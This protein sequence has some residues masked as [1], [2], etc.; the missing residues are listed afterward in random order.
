MDS[1]TITVSGLL[2]EGAA[3]TATPVEVENDELNIVLAFDISIYN[4]DGT[5]FEPEDDTISVTIQSDEISAGNGVYYISDDGD[6]EKMESEA[7]E[8][9]VA[10]DAEHFSTYAVTDSDTVVASGTIDNA[11]GTD[12]ITWTVYDDDA[13][14]RYLVITGTGAIPDYSSAAEQPWRSYY[15]STDCIVIG[16]GITKIGNYAFTSFKATEIQFSNT[17]SEIGK[18]A[19]SGMS[20]LTEVTIPG[21]VKTIGSD[22][23]SAC[24]IT[25]ITLGEGVQTIADR[26]FAESG[27]SVGTVAIPASVTSIDVNAFNSIE[28]FDVAEKNE[29]YS[30][31]E[32]ILFSKDGTKLIKYPNNKEAYSYTVEGG[33]T[34]GTKAFSQVYKTSVLYIESDV[35]FESGGSYFSESNFI[36][37]YFADDVVISDTSGYWFYQNDNLETVKLP[38]NTSLTL[39][40][41][42]FYGDY[43][44][45]ELTIPKGTQTIGRVALNGLNA[46]QTLTYDAANVTSI[47]STVVSSSMSYDLIVGKDVDTLP[48]DFNY[49]ASQALSLTF[50]GPNVINVAEGALANALAPFTGI[51]GWIYVDESGAVYQLD[52]NSNTATL[53]YVPDDV[54]KYTV[55][56][57]FTVSG[58]SGSVNGT[59]KVTTVASNALKYADSLTSITFA[60]ASQ[61][62]LEAYA[63][64][65]CETLTSVINGAA[66]E[67]GTAATV[68]GAEALGFARVGKNA[69]YNTGLT[70][71]N[72]TVLSEMTLNGSQSV[73]ANETNTSDEVI[74]SITAR[75]SDGGAW[76][77]S[78]GTTGGYVA[79][80][81]QDM[82]VNI[83]ASNS[84]GSPQT[85]R[86]YFTS[87]DDDFYM[88]YEVG[89]TYSIEGV[90]VAWYQDPDDPYTV[91]CEFTVGAH[92]TLNFDVP[93][94]YP[95]GSSDGGGLTVSTAIVEKTTDEGGTTTTTETATSSATLQLWWKTEPDEYTLTKTSNKTSVSIAANAEGAYL[96]D[97]L[98]Y[99]IKLARA[100]D[101]HSSLG[102]DYVTS[103][104]YTDILTLPDGVTWDDAV[105]ESIKNGTYTRSIGNSGNTVTFSANGTTI[106]TLAMTSTTGLALQ[107]VKLGVDKNGQVVLSWTVKNTG[108]ENLSKNEFKLTIDSAALDVTL[109]SFDTS[110]N[111]VTNT[112]TSEVNYTYSQSKTKTANATTALTVSNGT[113][114]VSKSA[115][116][117]VTYFGEDK[118]YTVTVANSGATT[119]TYTA[120][121]MGAYTLTDKLPDMV[122]IKAENME[123]MF[124]AAEEA[125]T[126]LTITITGAVLGTGGTVSD[127]DSNGTAYINSGNS[128]LTDETSGNTIVIT[129]SNGT[130]TISVTDA[131]GNVTTSSGDDLE[132]L[133]Q[134]IGYGVTQSAVYTCTWTMASETATYTL[135]P[136]E[137]LTYS[138]LSTVKTTFQYLGTDAQQKYQAEGAVPFT[139]TR[140]ELLDPSSKSVATSSSVSDSAKRE[141]VIDKSVYASDSEE[142]LGSNFTAED[143]QVLT[144]ELT[145]THYGSGTYDDLPMV[146]DL[147][148][149]QYL[150]VPYTESGLSCSEGSNYEAYDA[151]GD[152]TYDYY[153]LKSGTFYNVEVGTY[154]MSDGTSGTLTAAKI[155]VSSDSSEEVLTDGTTFTYSGVHT[156]IYWYFD[157][158]PSGNYTL[159]VDY[160]ALVDY[161]GSPSY[162]LGNVVW[163][164]DRTNARIYDTLLG[165]G[166]VLDWDK[167]IVTSGADDSDTDDDVID[168]D[169]LSE[170]GEGE[171][172]T[173]RLTLSSGGDADTRVILTGD[174]IADALPSTFGTFTWTANNVAITN[175]IVETSGGGQVDGY[176]ALKDSTKWSIESSWNGTTSEGQYYILWDN[177]VSITFT[178]KATVYVY[179]TLTFPDDTD[180][181]NDGTSDWTEYVEAVS[182][183]TLSNTFYVYN[184]P[185]TVNHVLKEEGSAKLTKGVYALARGTLNNNSI[186]EVYPTGSTKE[187]YNNEDSSNRYI[188]YYV[189]LYNGANSRLYLNDLYDV[190]PDGFTFVTLISGSSNYTNGKLETKSTGI[191]SI[192]TLDSSNSSS[193]WLIEKDS[194]V[195]YRSATITASVESGQVKFSVGSGS[196]TY[197]IKYDDEMGQYYL[198]TNE[199]IVFGFICQIGEYAD[200]ESNATNT[201]AMSYTDYTNAGDVNVAEHTV[202][203]RDFSVDGGATK[204]YGGASND[205]DCKVHTTEEVEEIGISD[206]TGN[207][208]WL[209]SDVTVSRGGIVPGVS[210][211]VVS[212]T[213]NNGDSTPYTT[214]VNTNMTVN[215]EATLY[216]RGT[217]T[218]YNYTVTDAMPS[219]F[220]F[221]RDVTYSIFDSTDT[222]LDTGTLFSFPDTGSLTSWID[223]T[224]V[225][226]S[227]LGANGSEAT[228]DVTVGGDAVTITTSKG[229]FT[230][231]LY[232]SGS[233][234][235]M[236]IGFTDTYWAIPEGGHV[237]L[238]YS[239]H[240]PTNEYVNATYINTVT[241][242]PNSQQ[243]TE[244]DTGRKTTD[245]TGVYATAP[246]TVATGYSTSAYKSVTEKTDTTNTARSDDSDNSIVLPSTDSTFTYTLTV[247]NSTSA[248]MS[249][250]VLIDN[251]PYVGDTY[252]FNSDVARGS[253]FAV[254]LANT[255]FTVTITTSEGTTT[256]G[257]SYYTVEG[258]TKKNNFTAA[259]KAGTNSTDW[260][261]I[262]ADTDLPTVKSIRVIIN[263]NIPAG[264]TV[265]VSFDGKVSGTANAGAVAWNNFGYTY[266][267]T[268]GGSSI[269]LEAMPLEVG[270]QVPS[271]PKL[272]KKLVDLEGND[273]KVD[274]NTTFTFVVYKGSE[275]KD[276][277]GNSYTSKEALITALGQTQ[278]KEVTITVDAEASNSGYVSL[279]WSDWTWTPNT[280]YTIT[281][282]LEGETY[283]LNK[284]SASGETTTGSQNGN[285]YTF[286]YDPGATLYLACENTYEVWSLELT[287][288][289]ADSKNEDTGEY[290][291]TLEGAVFVLY[292]KTNR[293]VTDDSAASQI[294][295][296]EEIWYLYSVQTTKDN[297]QITWTG[298][299]ED[300]YYLVEVKAPD[301]Y[302]LSYASAEV[303]RETSNAKTIT[304]TNEAGYELPSTGGSGT[305]MYILTGTVL[306]CG[307]AVV[308]LRRKA[309]E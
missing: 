8:G 181:D 301:G 166:S 55:P 65:N 226:V 295:V 229:T 154:T 79:L 80:T 59:Y 180:T 178:G 77:S 189:E 114:N 209:V 100:E 261:E 108:S 75:V 232:L 278:Y 23:F 119:Y 297:G 133:L 128:N 95:S 140:A 201:I 234:A 223:G 13:G 309:Q 282:F 30:S 302:N 198:D 2:P 124:K 224:T 257:S 9:A 107:N 220:V 305:W 240:N 308:L 163:M 11:N 6:A 138:I 256:L 132:E 199:S 102:E 53:I 275:V 168:D 307:A 206:E 245:G 286:T 159:T 281:E 89:K 293:N 127:A 47:D 52:V 271:A 214:A 5:V 241:L 304:V 7:E 66:S 202:S 263:Y 17:V 41:A 27:G 299:T 249:S 251:L 210:K 216:N 298:L 105:L 129:Y 1:A 35:K 290:E 118:T 156:E 42:T 120:T 146:D 284:W 91:Y 44:L 32:G 259:E 94:N 76:T 26:A 227:Y 292:S 61:V 294:E 116:N 104:T 270:V 24:N 176:N 267:V 193:A 131:S 87:T 274:V 147:Y 182:G 246:V 16:E 49:L 149:S 84:S 162:T 187:Y 280:T 296:G 12:T 277:D 126:P 175:V 4:A 287:K 276:A 285:S 111:T 33:V 172:V 115:D 231:K 219:P 253:E 97:N 22:A 46:L 103:A 88:N 262:T 68:S 225:T 34:I 96:A 243:F 306:C 173:Y 57:S 215:W 195:T 212:Y 170:V 137:T 200:T 101:K 266:S 265:S 273:Y 233:N 136:G 85:Y 19:F 48:A 237:T 86:V 153:I 50:N 171:T 184:Y 64:A 194:S 264:A 45:T 242:T 139:N 151:D 196:G 247:E 235:V 238:D 38:N 205:G 142:A 218:I 272:E 40:A 239:S 174:N 255:N 167:D 221:T 186:T 158:L 188:Y 31:K 183:T 70:D 110:K 82:T 279:D 160:Q 164:N 20:N 244:V 63:L 260:F 67:D 145:F 109:S 14:T 3:V 155:V 58:E 258:S 141:A 18:F 125:G 289:D 93:T 78:N 83:S 81:G 117:T 300:S 190:L 213:D 252:T 122:Y 113:I 73:T 98:V 236:E 228:T 143:G 28:A 51:S 21:N 150:L 60:D 123:T 71:P 62:T 99:T 217:M 191:T 169:D 269:T 92:Q 29:V 106:V 254:Q 211:K 135:N 152:N 248:T 69:F 15:S 288:V 36:A 25:S 112:A 130:Y 222:Q 161:G 121:T 10:F 177:S 43:N 197:A 208:Q 37:I 165:G 56:I 72:S 157:A 268:S 148:G 230:L 203:G 74:S 207:T 179:V 283:V 204:W 185:T 134:D 291:T 39:G 250:L 144:Y 303:S 54:T 90:S 192:T